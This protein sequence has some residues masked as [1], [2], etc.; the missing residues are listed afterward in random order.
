MAVMIAAE[1]KVCFVY[2]F[3]AKYLQGSI[4]RKNS[5]AVEVE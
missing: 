3:P 4:N 1:N 5:P 2:V